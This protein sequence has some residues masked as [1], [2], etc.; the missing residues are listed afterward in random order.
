MST[1]TLPALPRGRPSSS[2]TAAYDT[3]LRVFCDLILEINSRLDFRVSSRGWCYILE[4]HGLLKG[5]F[6]DAQ[7]LIVECRRRRLLPM[8]IVAE[9]GARSL[10]NLEQLDD[11]DPDEKTLS[12][13]SSGRPNTTPRS[14]SGATKTSTSRWRSR[15]ST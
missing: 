1:L 2:T 11:D 4:E 9:D 7:K 6:D 15:R 8:D 10:D 12:I 5:D 3:D 14:R 13:T